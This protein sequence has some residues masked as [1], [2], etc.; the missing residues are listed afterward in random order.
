MTRHADLARETFS[1][2]I[3]QTLFE[4]VEIN[5]AVDPDVALPDPIVLACTQDE[6]RRCF[7]LCLQFWSEGVVRADLLRLVNILLLKGD[8]N[9]DQRMQYKHIRA[10]YKHFRFA[11]MLYG[12]G[13]RAPP[14][15][16]ATVAVMGHLQDAFLNRDRRLVFGKALTLRVLLVWPVWTL[17]RRQVGAIRIATAD[18]FLAYRQDEIRNL[19][20]ALEQ[21]EFTGPEFHA[22]RKIVSRHVS[23]YDTLRSLEPSEHAYKMSRFLS[24]IN[25]LMGRRHD[26]M[27]EQAISGKQSYRSSPP[28]PGDIRLRLETLVERYPL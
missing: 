24:A 22:M 17:V 10:R 21:E 2:K 20:K 25:G 13:H 14:L 8:L 18:E 4:A 19:K 16:R 6:M 3:L 7:A 15:F 23:F 5:D 12:E 1:R 27:V 11:L 28:L 26:E 9:P